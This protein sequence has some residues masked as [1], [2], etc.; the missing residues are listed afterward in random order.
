MIPKGIFNNILYKLYLNKWI[1]GNPLRLIFRGKAR[2]KLA[3]TAKIYL[4]DHCFLSFGDFSISRKEKPVWIRID[5]GGVLRVKGNASFF[6][7]DD[8]RIF[9]GAEL[10]I[11]NTYINSDCKIRCHKKIVIGDGCAISHDFTVMDSDA[12]ALNGSIKTADVYIGNHVWI[13]T[14][15]T[16]LPGVHVG[17]GAVL[18]AGAVVTKDVPQKCVVAG[19]PAKVIKENVEW[20]E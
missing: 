14:R 16:V 3:D 10:I 12:H 15:V 11:G 4:E 13:G 17:D 19:S 1:D 20:N 9:K 2:F 18:A 8:I 6:Y 5:E 7:D